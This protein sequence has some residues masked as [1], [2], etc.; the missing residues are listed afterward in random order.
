MVDRNKSP[1]ES[2]SKNAHLQA[3]LSINKLATHRGVL[4]AGSDDV[5][6]EGVPFDVQNV[7][8]VTAD[9]G[10]VRVQPPRLKGRC[11]GGIEG[12]H[13]KRTKNTKSA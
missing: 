1:R 7:A 9:L 10:V 5:F 4:G 6:D 2:Q 11:A 8:V 13:R 12:K 3:Q